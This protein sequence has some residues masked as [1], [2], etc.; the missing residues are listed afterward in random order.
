MVKGDTCADRAGT[1]QTLSFPSFRGLQDAPDA[2]EDKSALPQGSSK[3]FICSS[4]RGK[5][6]RERGRGDRGAAA[7]EERG[8]R[9]PQGR[10]TSAERQPGL[11][12][13]AGAHVFARGRSGAKRG[14]ANLRR[15]G[16]P[17]GERVGAADPPKSSRGAQ[18]RREAIDDV[19]GDFFFFLVAVAVGRLAKMKDAGR[20]SFSEP[21]AADALTAPERSKNEAFSG[22]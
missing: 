9:A 19:K 11:A 20:S 10:D 4:E 8:E 5:G 3:E 12:G 22:S 21:D 14:D 7:L 1:S 15:R 16:R 13:A 17:E 6:E 18:R 2:S